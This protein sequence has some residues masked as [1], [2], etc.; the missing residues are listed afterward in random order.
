M[1]YI[2][3]IF[4]KAE[5][6]QSNFVMSGRSL[7][8]SPTLGHLNKTTRKENASESEAR[9]LSRDERLPRLD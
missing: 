8:L 2:F 4:M 3:I 9:L 6:Q 5:Q 1:F 7:L